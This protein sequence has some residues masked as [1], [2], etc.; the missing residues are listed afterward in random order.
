MFQSDALRCDRLVRR[1]QMMA[2]LAHRNAVQQFIPD[3]NVKL[4]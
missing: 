2:A 4:D 1:W 3:S